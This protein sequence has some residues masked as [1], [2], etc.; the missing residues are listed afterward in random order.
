M[1]K[2]TP[3]E[4]IRS[5]T[6]RLPEVEHGPPL[7]V[8]S[9]A[10]ALLVIA[11]ALFGVGLLLGFVVV[12]RH[13]GGP[14]QAV[15]DTVQRWSVDHRG[16]LV[17]VS[18]FVATY[19]DALPLGL[20]VAVL[21][22]VLVATIRTVRALVPLAAYL[23]GEFQVFTIRLVILRPRP[24]TANYPAPG[25][26]PGIHE[27]SYSFPSGHA[28]AVTAVL[29]ASATALVLWRRVLW[30]LLLAALA[31]SF[32]VLDTRLV[33]GVHWFSDVAFGW[34]LGAVWGVTVA[35]VMRWFDWGDLQQIRGRGARLVAGGRRSERR[36]E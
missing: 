28:V 20:F 5:R 18:K 36:R 19:L 9:A 24:P 1:S 8:G 6:R 17:G 3:P 33:I 15:D 30:P 16:P 26:V 29:F 34:L 11:A 35:V 4:A 14:M 7:R 32:F 10:V 25:A 22:L 27:T 2:R 21:S 31:V 12:G 23:G 13:G